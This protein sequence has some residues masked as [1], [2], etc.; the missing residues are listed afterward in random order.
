MKFSIKTTDILSTIHIQI[1]LGNEV[2]DGGIY[3]LLIDNIPLYIGEANYFLDRLSTHI[4]KLLKIVDNQN[5]L[6]YFGLTNLANNHYI[7]Y[8]ILE[9]NL[10]YIKQIR[11]GNKRASDINKSIRTS[12]EADFVIKYHPLTQ[13][14][15]WL[16]KEDINAIR[17]EHF[18]RKKDDML[19]L[20]LRKEMVALGVNEKSYMYTNIKKELKQRQ[21]HQKG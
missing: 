11:E 6:D 5:S 2:V 17:K 1:D 16:N 18:I 14:P 7:T 8:M 9:P 20:E 19:P 10:P 3:M 12:K 13:W 4:G 15:I 21:A